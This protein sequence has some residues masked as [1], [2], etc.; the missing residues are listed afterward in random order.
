MN[1]LDYRQQED[2]TDFIRQFGYLMREGSAEKAD[3]ALDQFDGSKELFEDI[4][5]YLFHIS[6]VH[7]SEAIK[8]VA[9]K[10]GFWEI[11][12]VTEAAPDWACLVFSLMSSEGLDKKS[13]HIASLERFSLSMSEQEVLDIIHYGEATETTFNLFKKLCEYHHIDETKAFHA[14]R[15][16][17]DANYSHDYNDMAN[18]IDTQYCA[19][20]SIDDA[21]DKISSFPIN[22][23]RTI[24]ENLD[25]IPVNALEQRHEELLIHATEICPSKALSKV[26]TIHPDNLVHPKNKRLL[27][28]LLYDRWLDNR[29]DLYSDFQKLA[30]TIASHPKLRV[31][32]DL[33]F[34]KTASFVLFCEALAKVETNRFLFY[35]DH[36]ASEIFHD[37]HKIYKNVP[38]SALLAFRSEVMQISDVKDVLKAYERYA[39]SCEEVVLTENSIQNLKYSMIQLLVEIFRIN[40]SKDSKPSTP[41]LDVFKKRMIWKKNGIDLNR[42]REMAHVLTFDM[43]DEEMISAAKGDKI[44]ISEMIKAGN[45]SENYTRDLSPQDRKDILAIQLGL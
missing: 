1:V 26:L 3:A 18:K 9:E 40:R 39:S 19:V 41:L 37:L 15:R 10:H 35:G 20:M 8:Q 28:T 4:V 12:R 30:D 7:R 23:R 43:S 27:R 17:L 31:S 6:I 45:L 33:I 21:L 44:F 16:F 2:V 14:A 25:H 36:G 38:P 29:P 13:I 5:I 32:I 42:F 22:S 11:E 34:G 24:I